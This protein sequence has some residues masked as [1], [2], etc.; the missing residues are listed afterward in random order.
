M[1]RRPSRDEIHDV[2]DFVNIIIIA[3]A[4]FVMLL[5]IYVMFR[6][7]EQRNPTPSKIDAQHAPRGGLDGH[8]DPHPGRHRD[9]VVQAADEQYTYPKADLTLKATGN[10]WFWEHEYPEHG[11]TF[12]TRMLDDDVARGADRPQ[13]SRPAPPRRRQRGHR[14]GQ[15]G[16]ATC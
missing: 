2:Y 14:S 16:G 4:V 11:I 13:H 7:N 15:Q 5:L 6:F 1:P 12:E 8:P 3:I 10:A 9:P